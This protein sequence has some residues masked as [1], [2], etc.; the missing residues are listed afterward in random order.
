[1][2]IERSRVH[3]K[4]PFLFRRV[5]KARP[6]NFL[7]KL[8]HH[9]RIVN[10]LTSILMDTAHFVGFHRQPTQARYPAQSGFKNTG[11]EQQSKNTTSFRHGVCS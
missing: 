3:G 4:I 7:K 10:R 9:S 11:R 6:F 8:Y 2:R 1:M 5:D